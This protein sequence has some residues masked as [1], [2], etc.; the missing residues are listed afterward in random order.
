MRPATTIDDAGEAAL[1]YNVDAPRDEADA[2][3]PALPE[4][5]QRLAG[6]L[7]AQGFWDFPT[8]QFVFVLSLIAIAVLF[9]LVNAAGMLAGGKRPACLGTLAPEA[10]RAGAL[11]C[12]VCRSVW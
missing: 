7:K 8:E 6:G 2:G 11:R 9:I 3:D 5:R 1:V 10:A 4:L 12:T